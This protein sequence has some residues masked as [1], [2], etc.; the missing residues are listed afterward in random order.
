ML[1]L[2]LVKKLL[3][4]NDTGQASQGGAGQHR[5][6]VATCALLVEMAAID[7]EFTSEER[8]VILHA[9]RSTYGMN[10]DEAASIME[11]AREELKGSIDLWQFARL[12]N[13]A[14]SEE[15][16]IRVI[17]TV[18]NV[19]YADHRL[20]GHEDHLVHRLADLLHLSHRQLI[21]AKI[22]VKNLI[23]ASSRG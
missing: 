13:E 21:D 19:V 14:F 4:K 23:P 5:I 16:K 1:M 3:A 15:E 20:D 12:I 22:R 9:M 2:D 17:E 8:D 7:G 6:L 18:W 10:G 11:A